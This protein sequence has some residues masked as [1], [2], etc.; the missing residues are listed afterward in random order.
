MQHIR[1][2]ATSPGTSAGPLF[3]LPPAGVKLDGIPLRP[4]GVVSAFLDTQ[5]S[6]APTHVS[7]SVR[8]LVSHTFGFPI[9][10]Q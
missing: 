6:L 2:W 9:S 10:G 4:P 8:W 1:A 3:G 7:W 5:V